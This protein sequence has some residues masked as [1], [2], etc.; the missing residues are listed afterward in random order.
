MWYRTLLT[1][2]LC[3]DDPIGLPAA[4]ENAQNA[5]NYV[6]ILP[7]S[8][9]DYTINMY[10]SNDL[11]GT[12]A[13]VTG[14]NVGS[15]LGL[16]AGSADTQRVEVVET[17]FDRATTTILAA[18]GTKDAVA[19]TSGI[20]NYNYEVVAMSGDASA[21]SAEAT[22]KV[23]AVV[24]TSTSSTSSSKVTS[25]PATSSPTSPAP[26]TTAAT[27]STTTSS[28]STSTTAR[29]SN[30]SYKMRTNINI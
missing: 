17:G 7:D 13:S 8:G 6:I 15:V 27:I 21:G 30:S 20:C 1:T 22:S 29:S 14:L 12:A 16:V 26:E 3:S 24:S 2:A 4:H 11:I 25:S 23:A 10:R 28:T 19:E 5:I 9:S 18:T